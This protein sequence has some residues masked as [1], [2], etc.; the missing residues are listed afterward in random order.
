MVFI[1]VLG[2]QLELSDAEVGA[3]HASLWLVVE[4]ILHHVLRHLYMWTNPYMPLF[5]GFYLVIYLGSRFSTNPSPN[6]VGCGYISFLSNL[7][8]TFCR[9]TPYIIFIFGQSHIV[10]LRFTVHDGHGT[11]LRLRRV[12]VGEVGVHWCIPGILSG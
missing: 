7:I 1:E 2:G 3:G 12:G 9:S 11:E 10:Q 4:I 6:H 5:V 8:P